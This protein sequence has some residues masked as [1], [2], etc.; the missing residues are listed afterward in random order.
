MKILTDFEQ[1]SSEWWAIHRGLPTASSFD[2]IITP[3]KG[4]ASAGQVKYMDEL[5]ADMIC[6]KWSQE[7]EYT[8]IAMQNGIACE[9]SARA[10]YAFENDVEVREVGFCL[11][12]CGRYG[13]SPD[14]LVGEVGGIEIKCPD[15][16]THI[17]YLREGRLPN[18]YKCQVHGSLAVTGYAWWDFISYSPAVEIPHLVIRVVPDDF[19]VKLRSEVEAFADRLSEMRAKF[20]LKYPNRAETANLQSDNQRS[21]D[22]RSVQK[23]G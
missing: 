13:C 15:L 23:S 5:I 16:K 20:G 17:G 9:P 1:C 6:H 3:V 18:E 10:W 21:E 22:A 4:E 12:D 7:P 11:S 14:G 8:S 19:T 2:R